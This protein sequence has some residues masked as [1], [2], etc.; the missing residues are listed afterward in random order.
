MKYKQIKKNGV[1]GF[2]RKTFHPYFLFAIKR[3]KYL[4]GAEI[5]CA[6]ILPAFLQKNKNK[7]L[8]LPFCSLK[9]SE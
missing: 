1:E 5:F 8:S 9:Q 4:K 3:K 6:I 2:F 7:F